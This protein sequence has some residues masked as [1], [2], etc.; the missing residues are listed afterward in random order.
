MELEELN[1][2]DNLNELDLFYKMEQ[3]V[4]CLRK[5]TEKILRGNKKASIR[6][7]RNLQDIKLICNIIRDKIQIRNGAKWGNA[8]VD[9]LSK[10]KEIAKQSLK[11]EQDFIEKR[12]N[13]RIER[14]NKKKHEK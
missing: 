2:M 5:D 14:L 8:R 3:M 9:S 4:R 13:E 11:K 7:R 1:E 10:A 6:V 12:K